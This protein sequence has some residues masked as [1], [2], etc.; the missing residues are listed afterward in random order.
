MWANWTVSAS[1]ITAFVGTIGVGQRLSS[2]VTN[3]SGTTEINGG[4]VDTT[5][6]QTYNDAVELGADATLTSTAAGT[7]EFDT[8]L[9]GPQ[10]LIVNT[11]GITRFD[12]AVGNVAALTS[13]TTDA[14]GTTEING[15]SVDTTGNQTYN[16]AVQLG[17]DATLTSTGAG[18]IEFDTILDGP[19]NLIVNTSGITRFDGAV[20]NVAALT[21]LTTDATGTTEINGGSVDTTGN[22]TYNDAVQLGADATLTST[23]AGTIEFDTILDG[24]QNLIVNTSGIT[25]FDG[26]VGN[27]AALTSLTTDAGGTTEING[28]S[29]DTTGNQTYNDAVQT[30]CRRHADLNRCRHD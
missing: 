30:R 21:S 15:G 4:S 14:G 11:S 22:Q 19:Q 23:G 25:R 9:D 10:N 29:V 6:N 1:G 8:I 5:G 16:D 7:I 28:G 2:L 27:V 26:A 13:L 20:G 18:T 24:P 3:N 17:A 12:G